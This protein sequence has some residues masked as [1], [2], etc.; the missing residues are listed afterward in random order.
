[1][2]TVTLSPFDSGVG[3]LMTSGEPSTCTRPLMM[4]YRDS[5]HHSV[6]NSTST[7]STLRHSRT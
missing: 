6:S 5:H 3:K 1:M 7:G 2:L 4:Q